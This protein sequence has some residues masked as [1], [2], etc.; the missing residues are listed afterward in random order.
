[1][2]TFLFLSV[3]V[4]AGTAGDLAV[5]HAM[6]Q[7]GEVKSFSPRALLGVMWRALKSKWIWLGIALM[8]VAFFALLAVLS[9][10]QVSFVVPATA[11][12]YVV[13]AA[14]ARFLLKERVSQTRWAGLLLVAAGVALVCAAR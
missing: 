11:A 5:T 8:T 7:I 12:N 2:R 13:G 9:W 4:L 10:A 1:M 6:K 3:V 14:G